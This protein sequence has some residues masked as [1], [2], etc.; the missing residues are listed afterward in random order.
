VTAIAAR[1]AADR[2]RALNHRP[3]AVGIGYEGHL[4]RERAVVPQ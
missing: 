2:L 1:R 3:S 4:S